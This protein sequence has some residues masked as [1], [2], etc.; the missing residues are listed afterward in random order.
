MYRGVG[1]GTQ[2]QVLHVLIHQD[3][4]SIPNHQRGDSARSRHLT[5]C[6]VTQFQGVLVG[7]EPY[8]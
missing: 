7:G 6:L 2:G 8:F 3:D 1:R 5:Y 4:V